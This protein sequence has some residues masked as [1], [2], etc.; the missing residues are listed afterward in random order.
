MPTYRFQAYETRTYDVEY[1]VEADTEE[2][3]REKAE[4]GD[5]LSEE[6]GRMTGVISRD[7]FDLLAFGED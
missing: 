5:T 2:E 6:T 1:V 7:I 4:Q 3:A